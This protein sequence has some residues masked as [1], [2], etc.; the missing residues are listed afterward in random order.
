MS[1]IKLQG[2]SSG[3]GTVTLLSP[4]VNSDITVTLPNTSSTLGGV[5]TTR[6]AV[7]TYTVGGSD[8]T[9]W[10]VGYAGGA[11]VAGST[12]GQDNTG[13]NYRLPMKDRHYLYRFAKQSLSGTW[14]NMC[15]HASAADTHYAGTL[16]VRIS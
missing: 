3:S 12:I 6:G 13:T 4:N 16:W 11:T 5:P 9:S 2:N 15:G 10:N 14:R 1:T 7:G 8:A